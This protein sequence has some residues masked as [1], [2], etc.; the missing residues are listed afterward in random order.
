MYLDQT[1]RVILATNA[2]TTDSAQNALQLGQAEPMPPEAV[3]HLEQAGRWKPVTIWQSRKIIMEH[4]WVCPGETL[5]RA[6]GHQFPRS[7]GFGYRSFYRPGS[8]SGL[9]DDGR[10][11]YGNTFFNKVIGFK[12]NSFSQTDQMF[13]WSHLPVF[14]YALNP[15]NPTRLHLHIVI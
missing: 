15:L 4:A 5:P 8:V 7:G 9:G 11:R 14:G 13:Y 6:Q 10:D 2:F 3:E 1:K 12:R